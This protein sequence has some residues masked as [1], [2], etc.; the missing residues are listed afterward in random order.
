MAA[1]EQTEKGRMEAQAEM[2][3]EEKKVEAEA[4]VVRKPTDYEYKSW[5]SG[6]PTPDGWEKCPGYDDVIRRV[7]PEL[8]AG[9]AT[10]PADAPEAVESSCQTCQTPPPSDD[11]CC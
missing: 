11:C 10:A 6:V 4:G 5:S 8:Q 1:Q 7:K 2:A 3:K 9:Q